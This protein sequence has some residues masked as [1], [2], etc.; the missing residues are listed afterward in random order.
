MNT[1][2]RHTWNYKGV[3]LLAT[4][5]SAGKWQYGDN[6]RG[7]LGGDVWGQAADLATAKHYAERHADEILDRVFGTKSETAQ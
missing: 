2:N 5:T 4:R 6:P 7:R 1:N 3:S